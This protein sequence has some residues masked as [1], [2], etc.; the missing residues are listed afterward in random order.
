MTKK[1]LLAAGCAAVAQ[2]GVTFASN[3]EV[4]RTLQLNLPPAETWNYI[5]DFCDIDDW[6]TTI[7]G[8]SLK[9]IDGKLYRILTP[10]DGAEMIERRIAEEP[11]LSYTYRIESSGLPVDRF[12]ATLSI[13]PGNTSLIRWSA[14]FSSDKP[15]VEAEVAAM[16]E[17]GMAGIKAALGGE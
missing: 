10:A 16:I 4:T 13:E 5:G 6:H 3:Y 7:K 14:R 12:T 11:G 2:S 1:I 8:C 17:A 15:E 9:A